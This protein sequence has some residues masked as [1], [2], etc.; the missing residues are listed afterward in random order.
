MPD[1]EKDLRV[2]EV[3]ERYRNFDIQKPVAERE[4]RLLGLNE[5]QVRLALGQH[6]LEE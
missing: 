2:E 5:T 4:L 6:L 3:V 1:F